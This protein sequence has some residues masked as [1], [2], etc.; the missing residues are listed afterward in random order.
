MQCP[1]CN[2][3]DVHKLAIK[4]GHEH[5]YPLAEMSTLRL[6]KPVADYSELER[7]SLARILHGYKQVKP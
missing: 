5:R 1:C 3:A 6:M 7:D 2:R 4:F